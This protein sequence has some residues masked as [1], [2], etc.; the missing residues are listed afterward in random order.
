MTTQQLR[1]ALA[2]R[3]RP[4][5]ADAPDWAIEEAIREF[6]GVAATTRLGHNTDGDLGEIFEPALDDY[7]V[8]ISNWVKDAA[9]R[10]AY[11]KRAQRRQA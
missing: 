7:A 8:T 5:A 10:A 1:V 6:V 2:L 11:R 9:R 3:V 4:L